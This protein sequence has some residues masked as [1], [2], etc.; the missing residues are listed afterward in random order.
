MDLDQLEVVFLENNEYRLLV[1]VADV[2][3]FV[4]GNSPI[5][6]AAKINTTSVYTGVK[7]FPMLPGRLSFD[8]TSLLAEKDRLAMVVEV[9]ISL[10][11]QIYGSRIFPALV[12]NKAKLCYDAVSNWLEARPKFPSLL[13]GK[14]IC[15]CS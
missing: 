10:N 1:A 7:N 9:H 12:R 2:D 11:G 3:S 15:A 5:D 6:K 13:P 8:L 14:K 4:T